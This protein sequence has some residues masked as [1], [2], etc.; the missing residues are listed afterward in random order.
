MIAQLGNAR[1]PSIEI[2]KYVASQCVS[3]LNASRLI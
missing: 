1:D 3:A 2:F